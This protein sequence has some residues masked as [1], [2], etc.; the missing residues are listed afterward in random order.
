MAGRMMEGAGRPGAASMTPPPPPGS[1]WHIAVNGQTTGPITMPQ[2]AQAIATGQVTPETL[3]W[4]PGMAA[5][6]PAGQV[7]QL[8]GQFAA[9]PPP[10]PPPA[11]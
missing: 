5:W 4:T 10:P 11:K 1:V 3:V 6:T 7:P 2:L 8:A 9:T